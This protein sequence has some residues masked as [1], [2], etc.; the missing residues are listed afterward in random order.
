IYELTRND[1]ISC[2]SLANKAGLVITGYEKVKRALTKGDVK[3]LLHANGAALNG[4]QK[5]DRFFLQ[6]EEPTEQSLDH[7]RIN[8]LLKDLFTGDELSLALGRSNVIHIGLKRGKLTR[9][10]AFAVQK[11]AAFQSAN[12]GTPLTNDNR[13]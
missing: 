6:P 1:A 9:R 2:L 8:P 11:T 10:F 12:E 13:Q 3:Y 5:L 7:Q 4:T